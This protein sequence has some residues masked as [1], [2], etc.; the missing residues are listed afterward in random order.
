MSGTY[1]GIRRL[2][3]FL[4][5]AVER[6][7]FCRVRLPDEHGHLVEAETLRLFCSC[8][9][10][11]EDMAD[12]ASGFRRVQ[13]RRE[14]LEDFAL[15]DSDWAA[16][17]IPIDVACL[18]RPE[19]GASPLA[20]FPGPAGATRSQL[21]GEVWAGLAQKYSLL[22]ELEPGAEA[23]LVN[24]SGGRRDH[25]R[26]STDHCY[27]LAGLMRAHWRGLAG[28]EEAWAAVDGYFADLDRTAGK[29]RAVHA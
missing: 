15:S 6:C 19:D 18:F 22:E 17:Q 28:G 21:S 7:D 12:G 25:Y 20:L 13:P 23:L 26:V 2:R 10:C 9:A 24:R 8:A 1:A 4:A 14:V 11:A 29:G 3:K 16:L 27:A 5:P